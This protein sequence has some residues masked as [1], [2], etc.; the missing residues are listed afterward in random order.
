MTLEELLKALEAQENGADM[1]EV[2]KGL[3]SE[4]TKKNNEARNLRER[5]K[6]AESAL[7]A[8]KGEL[9][10]VLSK[11]ELDPKDGE[12]IEDILDGFLSRY[13]GVSGS[14]GKDG[15]ELAELKADMQRMKRELDKVQKAKE[16]SEQAAAAE[17]EKRIR[18]E[19]G[20]KLTDALTAEKAISPSKLVKLLE[21]SV[22]VL[23]DDSMIFIG[24]DGAEVELKEGVAAFLKSNPEFVANT[25]APGSGSNKVG[26]AEGQ[27]LFSRAE[28]EA[29]SPEDINKNWD[30]VQASMTNWKQ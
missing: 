13:K 10:K 30:A 1:A 15:K 27:K 14:D 20:R 18:T 2:V 17:R 8:S 21:D 16:Q 26:S 6:A 12:D 11:L 28:L 25:Q 5:A 3:Q 7:E 22:K 24:D 29:M 23:D 4:V 9:G 19:K